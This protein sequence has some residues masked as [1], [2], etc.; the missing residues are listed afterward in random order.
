MAGGGGITASP[1]TG[2]YNI[3]S[4]RLG[5]GCNPEGIAVLGKEDGYAGSEDLR[6]W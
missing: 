2:G 4:P 6:I 5:D 1:V 3:C